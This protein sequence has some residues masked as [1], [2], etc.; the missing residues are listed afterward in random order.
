MTMY[1]CEKCGKKALNGEP[2]SCGHDKVTINVKK[3]TKA[4]N[5][6]VSGGKDTFTYNGHSM[7]TNYVKYLL[8]YLNL[9]K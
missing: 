5:A 4:Y 1:E 2:C 6:A 9:N 8:E 3:L 7:F